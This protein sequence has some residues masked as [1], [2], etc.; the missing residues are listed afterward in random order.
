[1]IK[2]FHKYKIFL[3]LTFTLFSCENHNLKGQQFIEHNFLSIIDPM[4]GTSQT[5]LRQR[6]EPVGD[7]KIVLLNQNIV[8]NENMDDLLFTFF[9]NNPSY[10]EQFNDLL[11]TVSY[12]EF[13][14]DRTFAKQIGKYSINV[15]SRDNDTKNTESIAV[16]NFKSF[17]NQAMLVLSTVKDKK[18]VFSIL[19]FR[20]T[21]GRWQ[22]IKREILAQI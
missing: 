5:P 6:D 8:Y 12:D 20:K 7:K 22:I 21:K 18:K 4:A 19:L 11:Y 2:V 9:G 3:L 16:E 15:N 10:R 1:M 17:N 13:S 14:I